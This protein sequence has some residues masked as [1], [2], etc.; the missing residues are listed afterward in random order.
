MF[1]DILSNYN[2]ECFGSLYNKNGALYNNTN[3]YTPLS[4]TIFNTLSSLVYTFSFNYAYSLTS[5]GLFKYISGLN[6]QSVI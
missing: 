1:E 4:A 2:F 5:I 6:H 3:T